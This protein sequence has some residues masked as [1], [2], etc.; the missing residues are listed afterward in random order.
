MHIFHHRPMALSCILFAL[1]TCLALMLPLPVVLAVGLLLAALVYPLYRMGGKRRFDYL[2]AGAL[3]LAM[4][5]SLP[6]LC[7]MQ[8]ARQ[9]VGRTV[10]AEGTVVDVLETTPYSGRFSL[11]LDYLNGERVRYTV[12]LET[13]FA[14]DL[15]PG[16]RISVCAVGRDFQRDADYEEEQ[17]LLS[18]G[19]MSVFTC[20]E[21]DALEVAGGDE[22]HPRVLLHRLNLRLSYG[23]YTLIGGREGGLAAALLW[24]NRDFLDPVTALAFRRT[25]TTHLLA[26]SG[27][28]VSVLLGS[29]AAL[30]QLLVRSRRIR[31]LTVPLVALVYL[32][33]TGM[34]PSATRAVL[35]LCITYLGVSLHRRADTLT[36]LCEALGVIVLSDASS[37]LDL[38]LWMSFL[39]AAAVILCSSLTRHMT[40]HAARQQTSAWPF[41]RRYGGIFNALLI[42][43]AANLSLLLIMTA[44][45]GQLALLALPWTLLTSLPISV[46]LVLS[47]LC[48]VFPFLAPVARLLA[49]WIIGVT[50][51][52]GRPAGAVLAVGDPWSIGIMVLLSLCL[53]LIAVGGKRCLR[54]IRALPLLFIAL[55]ITALL[56]MVLPQKGI[57][58]TVTHSFGGEMVLLSRNRQAAAVDLANGTAGQAYDL[59]SR[60]Q[61]EGCTRLNELILTRYYARAPHLIYRLSSRLS[62]GCLRLPPPQN[63]REQAI[64]KRLEEEAARAGIPVRYDVLELALP[65]LEVLTWEHTPLGETSS[66]ILFSFRAEKEVMT[67]LNEGILDSVL[68]RT[69]ENALQLSHT[70]LIC[71]RAQGEE[72]LPLSPTTCRL[73]ISDPALLARYGEANPTVLYDRCTFYLE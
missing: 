32:F 9:Y 68:G 65:T 39:A 70:V 41:L 62:V 16:D 36:V 66:E 60:L 6:F 7:R 34:S 3:A 8:Q 2:Y 42:G 69:A 53:V 10:Q 19:N 51:W 1:A 13:D 43:I 49:G 57:S 38:S 28:H 4:L 15:T 24:G 50:Q 48:T 5:L 64:A 35:M 11:D 12:V 58:V 26:L 72:A 23:M 56:P 31:L 29:L 20:G 47:L 61:R 63:E 52:G 18:Q 55:V 71:K 54:L 14:A 46:L 22:T 59:Y 30:L 25:G 17:Y 44:V 37:V 33:A 73:I 21:G 67:V 27:M 45:S 40:K